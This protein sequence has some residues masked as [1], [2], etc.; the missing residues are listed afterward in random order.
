VFLVSFWNSRSIYY[1]SSLVGAIIKLYG[2]FS[3]IS[4]ATGGIFIKKPIIGSKKAQDLP[5]PVGAKASKS[6]KFIPV[7][8]ACI[9][10]G[11]GVS[12]P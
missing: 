7:G 12:Y 8:M 2:P 6:L 3:A 5:E 1:A 11:V 9:Y 10:I 4:P